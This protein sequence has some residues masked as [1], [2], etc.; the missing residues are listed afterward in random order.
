MIK[1]TKPEN[2][3]GYEL[4]DELRNIGVEISD[5]LSSIIVEADG[6]LYL[7]IKPEDESKAALVVAA[8]NGTTIAP[9]PT[10]EDKLA[11]VGLSLDE[12]R[13]ALGGN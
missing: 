5:N 2:L 11:S 1:F 10:I 8:H 3:N 6:L 13:A 12:L 7:D 9:E 4:R